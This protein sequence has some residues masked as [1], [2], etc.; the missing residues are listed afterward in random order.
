MEPLFWQIDRRKESGTHGRKW[1]TD[2]KD[3]IAF[4]ILMEANCAIEKLEGFTLA[5]AE[6]MVTVFENLYAISLEIKHPND[7]VYQ[8][9]KIGGILTETKLQGKT[10]KYVVIGIRYQYQSKTVSARNK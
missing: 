1:F 5:I 2:E 3:N 8:G 10:V 4:S 7:I 6:M 9:K